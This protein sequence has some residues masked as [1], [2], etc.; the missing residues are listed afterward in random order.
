MDN[1]LEEGRATSVFFVHTASRGPIYCHQTSNGV[2]SSRTQEQDLLNALGTGHLI[3]TD[4]HRQRH[5]MPHPFPKRESHRTSTNNA[6]TI[7]MAPLSRTDAMA[8]TACIF[9]P[10][11]SSPLFIPSP[12]L[13]LPPAPLPSIMHKLRAQARVLRLYLGIVLGQEDDGCCHNNRTC[14]P[15][16]LYIRY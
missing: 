4:V 16:T 10:C 11:R 14:Q 7:P 8:P 9:A 15:P 5:L 1:S 13:S 2:L 12:S 6:Q 3:S